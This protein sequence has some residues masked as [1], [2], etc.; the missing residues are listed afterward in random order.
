MVPVE[1]TQVR[2]VGVRLLGLIVW[3]KT[4]FGGQANTTNNQMEL[5]AAIEGL[6]LF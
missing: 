2:E 1:V 5:S 3:K 4:I 6:W